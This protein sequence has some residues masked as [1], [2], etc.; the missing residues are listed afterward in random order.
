MSHI[1]TLIASDTPL[2]IAHIERVERFVEERAIGLTGKP[3]WLDAHRAADL[4][5][6]N[7]PAMEQMKALRDEFAGDRIDIVCVAAEGRRKKLLVAD[8]DATIVSSETLDELA[9]KAGL[10]DQISAITD[11][12]MNGELNFADALRERVALLK[13]LPVSA[14]KET[15]HE[16]AFNPGAET[17]V[18]TMARNGAQCILVSGGFSF[19]TQAIAHQ[20]GFHHHHGNTLHITGNAID[21]T[22]GEPILGK[23]EKLAHLK[24]HAQELGLDL[25]ETLAIGDGANDL[26]MLA[27]AGLGI[28]Y[29]PKKLLEDNLLNILKYADLTG[30][31]YA[32][33]YKNIC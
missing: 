27:A 4:P 33:G 5:V 21:G 2:S 26:P 1:L 3:D 19:F 14:L 18:R 6:A 31:L 12:A 22:V 15:L 8:M 20:A 29:H 32:Q 17:L 24:A 25:A 11:R 16:T 7:P 28:G 9:D 13:G 30:V 10:K 23:E